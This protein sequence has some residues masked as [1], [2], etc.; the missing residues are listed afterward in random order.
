M[1]TECESNLSSVKF[2]Q[3]IVM[4]L[5]LVFPTYL[6]DKAKSKKADREHVGAAFMKYAVPQST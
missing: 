1:C 6:S 4:T 3:T 2:S 5:P